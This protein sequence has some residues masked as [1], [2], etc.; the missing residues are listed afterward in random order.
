MPEVRKAPR[1]ES[2]AGAGGQPVPVLPEATWQARAETHAARLRP[3][4]D[5]YLDARSRGAKDPVLD[6]LFEYYAL[7]PSHLLRWSPGVGVVLAGEVAPTFRRRKEFAEGPR[8]VALDPAR[9]PPR[10]RSS[11]AWTLDLLRAVEARP[12]FLGCGGMHEWAMVYRTDEVRHDQLPLRLPPGELAAFVESRPIACSHF[13][14][15][16]FF[17][18]AARPLNRLQ[19]THARMSELEQPGCLH[20]NM[21]VYRWAMKF[22]PWVPA[23]VLADA[24][25]VA[26]QARRVDM[27]ASPYDLRAHSLEPI[28]IETPEGRRQ[29]QAAQQTIMDAAAPV[30]RRLIEALEAL[31]GALDQHAR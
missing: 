8:G 19:P 31:Q 29:Y 6:F 17:T 20:T 2:P 27:R 13:D 26:L 3:V 21:D 28:R 10:R 15:F 23:E 14:A 11:L 30:R 22:T 5:P 12:P 4:L 25:F 16:R 9:F 24:F 1:R 18:P 7:R